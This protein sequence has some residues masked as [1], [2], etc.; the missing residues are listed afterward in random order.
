MTYDIL[1]K[2]A[3]IIDNVG[4]ISKQKNIYIKDGLINLITDKLEDA[5][6]AEIIDCSNYF[7]TP[8]LINLHTHSPMSIFRGLAEDVH[9]DDWF[10]KEIWPY[11]SKMT[12]DDAYLGAL[13]AINEMINN[14]VTAFA[15]HYLFA[16]KI[17]DAVIETGIKADVAITIFGMNDNFKEQLEEASDIIKKR[18]GTNNR[19]NV[20]MGPH[21]PYTCPG[22]TLKVIIERANELKTGIHIHVSETKEQVEDDLKSYNKTPFDRLYE[23]GGFDIPCIIGHGLWVTKEDRKYF[24]DNV[25]I[26]TCPKT[27]MKL[28]MGHGNLWNDSSQMPLCTGT[29]GAASSNTLDPLEQARLFALIGKFNKND[30]TDFKLKDIWKMLMR[31]HEALSFNSG[32]IM[33]KYAADLVVWDLNK[34][35]TIPVYNPLASIVYSANSQNILYTIVDG[36]ILKRNG[37]V[38]VGPENIVDKL[39]NVSREI[40]DRGKGN[41]K[42][43]F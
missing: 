23:A 20:R 40:C 10:N 38:E 37:I 19:L 1:L 14:G 12:D 42:L 26:A 30:A 33:E 18:N 28:N 5:F 43:V 7:I 17:C 2:N 11:E 13:A 9:I 35:N 24:N 39:S 27:Y 31:G 36:K 34:S 41:T 21:A 29:D 32:K 4:K 3:N 22:D 6:V 15:D 25:F 8:G 16:D